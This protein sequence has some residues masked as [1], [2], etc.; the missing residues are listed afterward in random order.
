MEKFKVFGKKPEKSDTLE[1]YWRQG[2]S[3]GEK[4]GMFGKAS[5]IMVLTA[6]LYYRTMWAVLLLI[7]LF[8]WKYKVFEKECIRKKRNEF[9]LQFKEMIQSL[10]SA[11]GTGYSAENAL[12]EAQKELKLLY[13]EDAIISRELSVMVRQL[14]IHLPIEQILE[15]FS[16]RVRIEDVK[17][18]SAVF[19][20]AK[21]SGGDMIAIIQNTVDQMGG[22]IEVKR[23]IDT[24]LAAKRYEFRVMSAVPY[25]I[26]TYMSLS[27]P[28]F[29][30][31]L[32]GNMIGIG[33]MTVCLVIYT[34]ACVIG[35]RLA[36][37][38][39]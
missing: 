26:I 5:G 4:I 33:V 24:I 1:N 31:C 34:G 18:F 23:E 27:F 39:V 11:L 17:S 28:E 12:R 10:A 35:A 32:Y 8:I 38:E 21:R 7:P 36:D 16:R 22:K 13:P 14:R 30:S 15:E 19:S 20:A 2:I 3:A 6:W 29:M 25:A 37:I 9:L